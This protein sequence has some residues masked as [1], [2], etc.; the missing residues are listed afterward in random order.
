MVISR[1]R[2]AAKA[3]A[4]AAAHGGGHHDHI[5]T[6][7]VPREIATAIVL[8]IFCASFWK[9]HH[10]T[11]RRKVQDFYAKLEAGEITVNA[12]E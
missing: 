5:H 1:I 4:Q 10:M 12:V 8:G 6:K 7:I 2:L 11:E 3:V 9:M